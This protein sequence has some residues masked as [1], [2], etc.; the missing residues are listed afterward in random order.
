MGRRQRAQSVSI[1]GHGPD[2]T[3][4]VDGATVF[5]W[6]DTYGMGLD[7]IADALRARGLAFDVPGFVRAALA[8]GW[9]TAMIERTLLE[10]APLGAEAAV[11]EAIR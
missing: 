6:R 1:V 2:G 8:G 5:R 11:R 10:D 9:K 3:P 4:V 7:V